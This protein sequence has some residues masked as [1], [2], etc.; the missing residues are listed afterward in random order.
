MLSAFVCF[1]IPIKT[2]SA[3]TSFLHLE[4]S[5]ANCISNQLKEFVTLVTEGCIG[6]PDT[7][8]RHIK[9]W[10]R[11]VQDMASAISNG[12]KSLDVAPIRRTDAEGLLRRE[13]R[14]AFLGCA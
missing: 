2:R 8:R 7:M 6:S 11:V 13:L 4:R 9:I 14:F 10:I 1:A 3:Q 12:M 5:T